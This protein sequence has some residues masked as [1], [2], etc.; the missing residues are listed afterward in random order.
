MRGRVCEKKEKKCLSPAKKRQKTV[1]FVEALRE[2]AIDDIEKNEKIVV[3]FLD[4]LIE[5]VVIYIEEQ[6]YRYCQ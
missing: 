2:D 1:S 5:L 3:G 4:E 6:K